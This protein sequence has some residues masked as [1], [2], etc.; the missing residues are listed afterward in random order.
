MKNELHRFYQEYEKLSENECDIFAN[1][2][3]KLL[4]INYLTKDKPED[5]NNYY[6]IDTHFE[7]FESY[8]NLINIE[9]LH[10]KS[11]GTIVLKGESLSKLT[12]TKINSIILLIIR[13]LYHQRLHELSLS[14]EI[15]ITTKDIQEKY[16]QI[17]FGDERIKK[18][19]LENSL[20]LFKKYNLIN[21]KGQNYTNDDL[22]ITIY[23]TIQY[24]VDLETIESLT[25]MLNSY[26]ERRE[27]DENLTEN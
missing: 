7:C 11:Q 2:A 13:L 5:A 18:T 24:A 9:L 4:N 14:N 23:P 20:R 1:L 17:D 8:F 3:N 12:L 27:E 10:Y 6:F 26:K 25:Q 21:Y 16:E 22:I 19:D 15:L